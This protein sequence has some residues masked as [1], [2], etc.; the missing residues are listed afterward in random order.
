MSLCAEPEHVPAGLDMHA[1]GVCVPHQ[2]S[3]H[4]RDGHPC[5][6][7]R[8][9][10]FIVYKTRAAAETAVVQLANQE[11]EAFPGRKVNVRGIL[12]VRLLVLDMLLGCWV[13]RTSAVSACAGVLLTVLLQPSYRLV[14]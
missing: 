7:W 13:C 8:R 10:G 12:R 9:Y 4:G 6:C 1:G 11:L 5:A 14:V 3:P 2:Q